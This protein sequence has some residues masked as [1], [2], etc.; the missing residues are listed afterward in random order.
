MR[1]TTTYKEMQT[2][3]QVV[4]ATVNDSNL[5]V[6]S[7]NLV[8][9]VKREDSETR[10]RVVSSNVYATTYTA[11]S[12]DVS[13]DKEDKE[14]EYFVQLQAKAVTEIM[15]ALSSLSKTVITKIEFNVLEREVILAIYEDAKEKEEADS[16]SYANITKFKLP[17]IPIK[18]TMISQ[19]TSSDL[20]SEAVEIDRNEI[21]Y[22]LDAILPMFS[23]D[24]MDN[25]NT[26]IYVGAEQIYAVPLYCAVILKNTLKDK[27]FYDFTL[28]NS[29]AKFIKTFISYEDK[30]KFAKKLVS[31]G[32]YKITLAN[33][34]SKA[35]ITVKDLEGA[36][37]IEKFE[38]KPNNG[39]VVSKLYMSDVL[40][41]LALSED[42]VNVE[43]VIS[44]GTG[45]MIIECNELVQRVPVQMVKGSG[46]FAFSIR[47]SILSSITMNHWKNAKEAQ[48]ILAFYV[49]N[50]ENGGVELCIMDATKMWATKIKKLVLNKRDFQ[51][52]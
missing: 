13:F 7:K 30:I 48:D 20:V 19:I 43:I 18:P 1:I 36:F 49:A 40:K 38:G 34:V 51:W 2:A 42:T 47:P 24:G 31:D 41:R 23:K 12:A 35:I 3:L 46:T 27:G 50:N 52:N 14:T 10:L 39:I 32:V 16:G 37:N 4:L 26:R 11:I 44:E 28:K 29:I 33:S 17:R 15:K 21:M 25:A 5:D 22:Y 9:W 45:S 8:F 6:A